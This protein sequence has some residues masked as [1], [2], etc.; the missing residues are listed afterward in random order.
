MMES[1]LTKVQCVHLA[2]GYVRVIGIDNMLSMDELIAKYGSDTVISYLRKNHMYRSYRE[3]DV[4]PRIM[5][6]NSTPNSITEKQETIKFRRY[7]PLT[8]K[9]IS[10]TDYP[11]TEPSLSVG[12]VMT[13]KELGKIIALMKKCGKNLMQSHKD[14][15]DASKK[16]SFTIKI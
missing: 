14:T 10:F 7:G 13:S 15:I 9:G 1:N 6:G 16:P 8:P 12:D 4:M 2:D 11:L 5:F 3:K